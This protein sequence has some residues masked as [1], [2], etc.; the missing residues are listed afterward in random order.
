MLE[1]L[2]SLWMGTATILVPS[3]E[4]PIDKSVPQT[5]QE[6][7]A[8]P[9]SCAL[10]ADGHRIVAYATGDSQPRSGS[11]LLEVNKT[12]RNVARTRQG[13]DFALRPG[14]TVSLATV[15]MRAGA[16]E[17]VAGR[18]EVSW[19]GGKTECDFH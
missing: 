16:G 8:A 17:A 12:G 6:S 11:Y 19:D 3:A 15:A 14:E 7:K 13:G 2:A 5:Q 10:K 9:V 18:L 4:T 1:F